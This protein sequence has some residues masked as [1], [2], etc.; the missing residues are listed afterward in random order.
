M[1]N[2]YCQKHKERLW[3]EAH[4]KYQNLSEKEKDKKQKKSPKKI[5]KSFWRTK[6]KSTWVYEKLLV[7]S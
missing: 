3:K 1:T 4:Q 5:S 2:R 6:A 7:S